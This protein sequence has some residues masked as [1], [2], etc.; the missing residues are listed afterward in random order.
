M[1]RRKL[2]QKFH[3]VACGVAKRLETSKD[4]TPQAAN[5][6]HFLFLVVGFHVLN[7]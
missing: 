5:R 2:F 7:P 3:F 4:A 1:K 6:W